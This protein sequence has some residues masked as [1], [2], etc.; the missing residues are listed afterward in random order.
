MNSEHYKT[1]INSFTR[2]Y[3]VVVEVMYSHSKKKVVIVVGVI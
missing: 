2:S 1:V 3:N